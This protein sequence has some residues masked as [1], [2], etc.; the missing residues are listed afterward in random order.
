MKNTFLL[1]FFY[2]SLAAFAQQNRQPMV[3]LTDV[4][5]G[6]Y[7]FTGA[8][9]V[10][11]AEKT[12]TNATLIV[13]NGMIE[14][15]GN[16]VDIPKDAFVRELKGAY[17]YPG[18]IDAAADAS[19]KSPKNMDNGEEENN[20]APQYNAKTTG[21]YYWND[22]VKAHFSLAQSLDKQ[23]NAKDLRA[24]GFAAANVIP[25]DGIF[26][27][28]GVLM[29]LGDGKA[30][31]EMLASETSSVLSF[32]KGSSTQMYPN[33]LMGAI[34]LIRQTLLDAEQQALAQ[35]MYAKN[36]QQ[37][38]PLVNLTLAAWNEQKAKKLPII[39]ETNSWQHTLAASDIAKEFELPFIYKTKGDEYERMD[40]IV[41]LKSPFIVSLKM[42]QTP[43]IKTPSEIREIPFAY[44]KRWEQAAMNPYLLAKNKVLFAFTTSGTSP[45]E[46]GKG[47]Q[48]ALQYGLSEAD[49]LR[50]LTENP[51]KI[52]GISEQLGTLEKGKI[53]NFSIATGNIFR[54][55]SK[56]YDL[57]IAGKK[58]EINKTLSMDLRGDYE[59]KIAGKLY[60]WQLAGDSVKTTTKLFE[61][62]DTNA[63]QVLH[64]EQHKNIV[65][66][67]FE[68]KNKNV[69][70]CTGIYDFPY[71]VITVQD[72]L[73]T[74]SN[75][76]AVFAQKYKPETSKKEAILPI[77][78]ATISPITYPNKAYGFE[79]MPQARKVLFKNITVWTNTDKGILQN[80]DVLI[81]K[82][83]IA[84]VGKDIA[85]PADAI[86]INGEGK[87]L[88]NGIIDEHSH[89]GILQGVNEYSHSI[90][91]EVRIGDALDVTDIN[92]YRQLS[93]G[94]TTSQ[95]LHG[96]ANPIGGQSQI[97]KLRWG[98]GPEEMKFAEAPGF[99]KFALGENAKQ[100]NAGDNMTSRYPQT[101]LGVEQM[102]ADAFASAK[103][104]KASWEEW[105]KHGK[106]KHLA[107][108]RKDL[109]L[110]ALVEI[111]EGKRHITCHSYVQSEIT[112]LVRLAES[113]GFKVNTFTHIL[114]GYKVADKLKQHG[115]SASTFSD[116]WGY[117]YEV[118][119]A[120][121]YNAALL[122]QQG[123]NVCIN[124][125]D[126]EMGRRLNQEAAKGMKYGGMT[127]EQAWKM[128]TLNPA[129]ALHID[130]YVGTVEKGKQADLVLWS[131]NPLS[132]YAKVVNTYI[133]GK[134]Y[135]DA[136][137]DAQ[138][139]AQIA[140][141]KLR[142]WQKMNEDDEPKVETSLIKK[143]QRLYHCDSEG[144]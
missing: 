21:A 126:A 14:A 50:A 25:N 119:E 97:I 23:D 99:I 69:Y 83:K 55:E 10:V 40:E 43:N 56:I 127:E 51:A 65:H 116:W 62:P 17:I 20:K 22:A 46:F 118:I 123:L 92:I 136:A 106:S 137:Q 37:T 89:I 28:T 6:V 76:S 24:L 68:N 120:T 64:F 88:T 54:P 124:S 72:E 94:V 15:I 95:L 3:Q 47:L 114:E 60:H 59:M 18:F 78:L 2:I 33:S 91:S 19:A 90:T 113:V 142:I 87:H 11:S 44:F 73:G 29:Q 85:A 125:D 66:L 32:L 98:A 86:V 81:E 41:S 133:D 141:E 79:M 12:L 31:Q 53:A 30:R 80:T 102:I 75:I 84:A 27:G 74:K 103:D 105:E 57:Y 35:K 108:P 134:C 121:P 140:T 130:D 109:Q 1:L 9:I 48:K 5:P 115:A 13:R 61:V 135:F 8:T 139:R 129:K 4:A 128:V 122:T 144:E 52:L 7:A 49:A 107:P 58:Y 63:L 111:L 39:F 38:P 93:G 104:Y 34:A 117:K 96:S 82:G 16:E 36:P 100:S 112:M 70:Q 132:V 131:D 42:P 101:R 143:T 67:T 110:A 77:N 138:M 45:E 26:S 71:F